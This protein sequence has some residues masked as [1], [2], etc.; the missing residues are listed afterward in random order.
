MAPRG[1]IT[2]CPPAHVERRPAIMQSPC[3]LSAG[4]AHTR[5]GSMRRLILI[6]TPTDLGTSDG[7][8][9]CLEHL[10]RIAAFL[11]TD[12]FEGLMRYHFARVFS[13]PD[14]ADL[15]A[16]RSSR[17]LRSRA[18]RY[19][20]RQGRRAVVSSRHGSVTRGNS[21]RRSSPDVHPRDNQRQLATHQGD[22]G[23]HALDR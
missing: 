13:E 7:P 5:P 15:A 20:P 12:D 14:V 19:T 16:G 2:V 3:M 6:G 22:S 23:T 17:W 9:Q 11:A 10:K 4:V 1:P 21:W 8:M 18:T